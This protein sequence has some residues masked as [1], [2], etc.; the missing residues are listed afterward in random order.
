MMQGSRATARQ[1]QAR[2]QAV[3]RLVG[4]NSAAYQLAMRIIGSPEQA[5]DAVQQAYSNAL[6]QLRTGAPPLET[7]TWFLRV[8]ANAAKDIRKLEARRKGREEAVALRSVRADTGPQDN[9]VSILKGAVASL[10]EKY[11][12]PLSLR[13][14]QG[15]SQRQVAAVLEIPERTISDHV[16]I[17]LAKLRK[18]LERAGYPAAVAAVLGGLKQTAPAAPTALAGRVE[19]L[20]AQGAMK[21]GTGAMASLSAT[22]KGGIAMKLIAGVVLAGAVAAGV[23]VSIKGGSDPLTAEAPP[24]RT[25]HAENQKYK[26]VPIVAARDPHKG[27]FYAWRYGAAGILNGPGLGADICDAD[28][29]TADD[30]GNCYW[31]EPG[32]LNILRK[33]RLADARVVTVAGSQCGYL[34]GP[35]E[36]A[37]FNAWGGGG[38]TPSLAQA[39][40][41]GKHIFLRDAGNGHALRHVDLEAG[42]VSTVGHKLVLAKDTAGDVYILDPKGGVV[43]P[44]KGY[45]TLKTPPLEGEASWWGCAFRA[46]DV[47]K[48]RLYGEDRGPIHYWDLKTGKITWLTWN[49]KIG[50]KK[51]ATDTSGPMAT[52]SFQCPVGLTISPGGRFLYM[53]SG[54]GASLWRIDLEKKY[55]HILG[56]TPDGT[57]TFMDGTEKDRNAKFSDWPSVAAFSA[58]GT[59]YWGTPSGIFRLVPVK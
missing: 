38:Y 48:G 19:A 42:V 49:K 58:D 26:F 20:V 46:L 53:G 35:L 56:R 23:A 16:R 45:K 21:T 24:K 6:Q 41:D 43:P 47:A 12:V 55:V 37:R 15:L 32:H 59:G 25:E 31:T 8:V 51:R 30:E 54:D 50:G 39:S 9:T 44:G 52:S 14:E 28:D 29:I 1:D 5:E 34:D 33:W 17:G 2:D 3:S 13:Y 10:E 40:G 27:T 7:R 22:A 18:A 11:R 4:L 57:V 36:R